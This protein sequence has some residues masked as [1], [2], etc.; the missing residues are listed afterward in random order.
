MARYLDP[1]TDLTFKKIFGE[2]PDLAMGTNDTL[3]QITWMM[4]PFCF[5]ILVF[6]MATTMGYP[7]YAQTKIDVEP[8]KNNQKV[9]KRYNRFHITPYNLRGSSVGFTAVFG[10]KKNSLMSTEDVEVNV[11]KRWVPDAAINDQDN[12]LYFVEIKNKTAQ[13]IYIDKGNSFRIYNDSSR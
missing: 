10:V 9:I 13:T 7:L 2:H 12:R 11:V 4:K 3:N 1:K 8:D 5:R 6:L